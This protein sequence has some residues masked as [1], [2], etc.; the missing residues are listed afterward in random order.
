MPI[1]SGTLESWSQ[2]DSGPIDSAKRTHN[3][4]QNELQSSDTLAHANSDASAADGWFGTQPLKDPN[5]SHPVID[6]P[7]DRIVAVFDLGSDTVG[8][9]DPGESGSAFGEELP[10]GASAELTFTTASG[11]TTRE[12][13]QVP[14]T[15]GDADAVSL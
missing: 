8:V 5:G 9:D 3:R 1:D 2:Y 7:D 4:I 11:A 12:V 15:F 6:E 13:L 10:T 14:E